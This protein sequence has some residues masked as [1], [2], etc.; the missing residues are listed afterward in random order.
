MIDFFI[1]SSLQDNLAAYIV[2]ALLVWSAIIYI[3][4]VV[5]EPTQ[6][7]ALCALEAVVSIIS[8]IYK[9]VGTAVYYVIFGPFRWLEAIIYTKMNESS[10]VLNLIKILDIFVCDTALEGQTRF[11]RYDLHLSRRAINSAYKDIII[12]ANKYLDEEEIHHYKVTAHPN[13]RVNKYSYNEP[14]S[15]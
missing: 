6:N 11:S 15:L 7:M 5:Y 3:L 12:A 2:T 9:L 4:S 1:P 8:S 13:K 14:F 10:R